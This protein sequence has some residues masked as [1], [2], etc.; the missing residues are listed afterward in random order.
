MRSLGPEVSYKDLVAKHGIRGAEDIL[1]KHCE[2][3]EAMVEEL[4]A[5]NAEL[6]R[7]IEKLEENKRKASELEN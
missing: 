3:V 1:F 5:E 2:E 7:R 4:Q 6:T